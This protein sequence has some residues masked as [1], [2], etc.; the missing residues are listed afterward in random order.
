ME[1]SDLPVDVEE[2]EQRSPPLRGWPRGNAPSADF[3]Q[4][5]ELLAPLWE[6][7][8]PQLL[9]DPQ[10]GRILDANEAASRFYGWSR[11]LLRSFTID[12]IN[13]LPPAELRARLAQA[14]QQPRSRFIFHHR[15]ADGHVR[16][17]EVVT[18]PI[19]LGDRVVLWSTIYDLSD[20]ICQAPE[21]Q[22][23]LR[24][25][26]TLVEHLPAV[27]YAE[28]VGPPH[29]K[30]YVSPA[31]EA[32]LGWPVETLQV[33]RR[34]W[35]DQFVLPEDRAAALHEEERTDQG[36]EQFRATYRFRTGDGRLI[37]LRDEAV[38]V[39]DAGGEPWIWHGLLTDVTQQKRLETRLHRELAFHQVLLQVATSLV[40]A[41]AEGLTEAITAALAE[42]GNFLAVH[43]LAFF[44]CEEEVVLVAEW[45]PERSRSLGACTHVTR[46][47]Q[48]TWFRTQLE[49]GQAVVIHS[50]EQLSPHATEEHALLSELGVHA[51]LAFPLQARGRVRGCLVAAH[52]TARWWGEEDLDLIALVSQLILALL[53]AFRAEQ[54]EAQHHAWLRAT[55]LSSPDALLVLDQNGV[56]RFASPATQMVFGIPPEQMIGRS[57]HEFV[58]ERGVL[59]RW[60]AEQLH[61]TQPARLEVTLSPE[62]NRFVEFSGVDL[63]E[64]PHIAGL[65]LSVRD[66]TE[67]RRAEQLLRERATRDQLTGLVNRFGF[68]EE[69]ERLLRG[70]AHETIGV[71]CCDLERFSLLNDA[72]GWEAGDAVLRVVGQ[73]LQR[74]PD[75]LLVARLEAD[76]FALVLQASNEAKLVT[77]AQA[78]L[79]DLSGWYE[80]GRDEVYLRLRGGLA[81]LQPGDE[82]ASTLRRAEIAFQLAKQA[83]KTPL[84]VYDAETYQASLDRQLLERDL[85]RAL[86]EGELFL[87]YQ[88]VLDLGLG[89]VTTL[90]ALVRWLHPTRGYVSPAVFIPLAEVT[91]L[92]SQLTQCVLLQACRQLRRWRQSKVDQELGISVN[93]SPT[94]F[95][96][97]D[98]P[99]LVEDVLHV[100]GIPPHALTLELTESAMLDPAVSQEHLQ[101]LRAM[102]VAVV[103]DD[104]GAGY[105]SLAYLKRLA[106]SGLKLDRELVRDC[107]QSETNRA[108]IRAV[109]ELAQALGLFVTAEGVENTEQLVLLRELG[110]H[111][112]QGF[113]IAR[114]MAPQDVTRLLRQ[115]ALGG[116]GGDQV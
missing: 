68:L 69:F 80:V 115:E 53:Q 70:V 62:R 40:G 12:R 57:V 89:K 63:R 25:Y 78:L 87:H 61:S 29:R 103:I 55:V 109:L 101:R 54:L 76:R 3:G 85:R 49:H 83:G 73:R 15:F 24:R 106:V 104:F 31:A 1:Q 59:S 7:R 108:V 91:G 20:L 94:D 81:V 92:I 110:C 50:L 111:Y 37:W 75:A 34:T 16:P 52:H 82:A 84:V 113:R 41:G 43:R 114:P 9:I 86:E 2:R 19:Q 74:V 38:L 35:Y 98:I 6:S 33:D 102:G 42:I 77:L 96:H 26:Q 93:L 5:P 56:V 112:A 88:P 21:Y 116:F 67:R 72:M 23:I 13:T 64:D 39:R 46:L 99:Q 105:S 22:A 45:P 60:L 10:D 36:G 107:E 44:T 65:V 14:Q 90:E 51:L 71:L 4:L 27:V 30:L 17:V 79:R 47:A 32:I 100:T 8:E 66:V 97:L 18:G 11:D 58:A 48:L 95:F 28:E